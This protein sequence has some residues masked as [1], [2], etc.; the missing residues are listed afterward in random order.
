MSQNIVPKSGA[1]TVVYKYLTA[2]YEG[3]LQYDVLC[4][5]KQ[6]KHCVRKFWEYYVGKDRSL[7]SSGGFLSSVIKIL[8]LQKCNER[9]Y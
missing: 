4:F 6:A 2:V 8:F 5:H 1:I 9:M 3:F 7:E